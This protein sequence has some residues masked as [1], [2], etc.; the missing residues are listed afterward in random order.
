MRGTHG[1]A[2]VDAARKREI[3]EAIVS[4]QA[5]RGP[6]H[7]EIDI[8]DRCNVACYFCN[9]QDVR[10]K[11]QISL[12]HLKRLVDEL[13]EGGLRSIRMSGGGDPLFHREILEFLD[14]LHA[15][16]IVVDN[17]T[18][19]GALLNAAI[20]QRLVAHGAREVIFSLNAVD[21]ADYHRMMQSQPATFQKVVDNVRGLVAARGEMDTPCVV[22][23]FLIDRE[24]YRELPRMYELGRGLG[25]DRISVASVLDIPLDRIR[26]DVLLRADDAEALRPYLTTILE[27]D[28][29]DRRLQI[30]FPHLE[31]RAV[32]DAIQRELGYAEEPPLFP[33]APAFR[34]ANGH[35]FFGWYTATIRGNGDLYP[36]CLL[37]QPDYKPLGNAL[38][39]RFVDHWNGPAFTKMREEQREVLLAGDGARFDPERHKIIRRQCV[40]YGA[41]WL[42]NLYFRG[43]HAFYADLAKALDA[44]RAE[45]RPRVTLGGIL[46]SFRG[47]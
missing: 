10:T 15:R 14:H 29:L 41:C 36:C 40:E 16:G 39:G 47:V 35:C 4:G 2:E 18:T 31:W 6:V 19:N 33:T 43:D 17:L 37:M 21:A 9:Q 42:K 45:P 11:D 22:V 32:Y 34:E 23:Q 20:A 13:A 25:A 3:I 5:T 38:N 30:E 44:A 28:K 7:A 12:E 26:R 27:R 24:N 46:R 1:W 8:T